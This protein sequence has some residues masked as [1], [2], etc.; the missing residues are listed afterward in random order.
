MN[1]LKERE[2]EVCLVKPQDFE[3]NAW[4]A[5][6]TVVITLKPHR[7]AFRNAYGLDKRVERPL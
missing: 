7:V 3:E 4:G 2:Y 5:N 1:D 6:G